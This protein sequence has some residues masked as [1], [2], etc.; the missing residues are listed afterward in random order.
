MSQKELLELALQV[1]KEHNYKGVVLAT[2]DGNVFL[3]FGPS[4]RSMVINHAKTLKNGAEEPNVHIID[5]SAKEITGVTLNN[6]IAGKFDAVDGKA[7]EGDDSKLTFD[8]IVKAIVAGDDIA[9]M[10]LSV[11]TVAELKSLCASLEIDTKATKKAD[12]IE[13][14]KSPSVKGDQGDGTGGNQGNGSDSGAGQ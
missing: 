5:C 9:E 1:A 7:T 3:G 12:L 4:E 10:D 6:F 11:L 8:E 14:I 2:S 13:A